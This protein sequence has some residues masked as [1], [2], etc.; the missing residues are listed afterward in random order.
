MLANPGKYQDWQLFEAGVNASR[1]KQPADAAKLF[2]A[3]LTQNP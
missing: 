3:G 1:A 2:E